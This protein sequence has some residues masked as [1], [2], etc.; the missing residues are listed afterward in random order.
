MECTCYSDLYIWIATQLVT[1]LWRLTSNT[2][3]R[4][5]SVILWIGSSKGDELSVSLQSRFLQ[6]IILL[7]RVGESHFFVHRPVS[8]KYIHRGSKDDCYCQSLTIHR[9]KSWA[10]LMLHSKTPVNMGTQT[11]PM[12]CVTL[13]ASL[14]GLRLQGPSSSAHTSPHRRSPVPLEKDARDGHSKCGLHLLDFGGRIICVLRGLAYPRILCGSALKAQPQA[15]KSGRKKESNVKLKGTRK[16]QDLC[17]F[18]RVLWSKK[19]TERFILVQQLRGIDW[20]TSV[21][22]GNRP[23]LIYVFCVEIKPQ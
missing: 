9:L 18:V 4:H 23:F 13:T 7:R 2:E 16:T 1:L 12:I 3:Q 14:L 20:Y 6:R 10:A 8:S 15:E 21:I 5:R 11:T 19:Q 22:G 17:Q